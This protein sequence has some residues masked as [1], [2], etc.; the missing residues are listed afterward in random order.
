MSAGD[1]HGSG[2]YGSTGQT[3]TRLPDP[4][5][6]VYGG[7]RR[8]RSS[9]PRS[10]VTVVG[11]VVLLIAAIAFANRGGSDSGTSSSAGDKAA[12]NPTAASGEKAVDAKSAGIPTGYAH[13]EQGAQ[14]A[15]A[16]YAV[17]LGSTGMFRKD[18][19]RTIVDTVYTSAAASELQGPLDKAY[20]AEFLSRM[21]L[22]ADGNPP[23]GSTFV[24]RVVPV[25]TTVREYRDSTATVAV[26]SMSLIGMS[27]ERTTDP[28]TTAWST[29]TFD[30]RWSDGDWKIT[31]NSQEDGPAPVPG[32]DKAATSE[33][34]GTAVEEYGGFTYAR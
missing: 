1:E 7:A 33:E 20:S 13:D 30:L 27:G 3:R 12:S 17:T 9:S 15:A 28:V 8:S 16:N 26:W 14:S 24:S 19:R 2:P 5:G 31:E 10:L 29:W 11:V 6:D 34:I 4:H 25:G 21:G 32:D 23:D 22:D 18:S